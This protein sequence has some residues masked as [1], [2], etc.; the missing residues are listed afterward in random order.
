MMPP[1]KLLGDWLWNDSKEKNVTLYDYILFTKFSI[2][3]GELDLIP[4]S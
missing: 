2:R 4:Y 3:R 1:R